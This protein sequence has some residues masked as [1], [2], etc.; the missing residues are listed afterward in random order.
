MKIKIKIKTFIF[1]IFLLGIIIVWGIPAATL[2]IADLLEYSPDKATLFYEKYAAYPTTSN[3]KGGYLYADSLVKSFSKYSIFLTGWGGGEDTSPENMKKAENILQD[4]MM[5]KPGNDSEKEYYIDSYKMLLDMSIATG[6]VDMLK[7]WISFGQ[8]SNEE[9]LIYISDMYNGFFLHVNG[10][11]E[12]AKKVIAKYENTELA[13]EKLDVLK[14]EISLFEG[15]YET[16]KNIYEKA[17]RD[18]TYWTLMESNI[19][20]SGGYYDRSFW[21]ERVMDDFK[22]DNVI[23]G[24]VTFEGEPMPFVE[25]YV[26]AVDGGFSSRG[27]SY[28]GITDENGEFETLGLKDGL[29]NIGIGVGGSLLSNKVLQRS[30]HQYTELDGKDGEIDFVFRNTFTVHSPEPGQKAAGDEFT[31]SWDEVEGAA[32]YTVEPVISEDPYKK[33]GTNMRSP[34]ADIN[35]VRKIKD[36]HATF[37][38]KMLRNQSMGFFGSDGTSI[39]PVSVLGIFLPGAEYPIVVNA[40]DEN[41]KLITSSLPMRTYYDQVPSIIVEGRLTVGEEMILRRDYPAAIEYYENILNDNPDDIDALR[42]LTRIYGIGWKLGEKNLERAYELGKRF[43]SLTGDNK[44]LLSILNMLDMDEIKENKEIID[45]VINES[46]GELEYDGNYFSSKYYIAFENYEAAREALNNAESISDNLFYLNMY[47]GDYKEAAENVKSNNYYLSRLSSNKIIE[48][49]NELENNPPEAY[50]RKIFNDFLLNL[51]KGIDYEDGKALYDET[52]KKITNNSIKT[53]LH[54][55]SL[56]RN[57]DVD[58]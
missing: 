52:V 39:E 56:D 19:Y 1:L 58:Y 27:E 42:Y 28:I 43:S 9:K 32:Y 48:S 11:R 53:I 47:F 26:Q 40:Y 16:A 51:V 3:I 54:E 49:L 33:S 2:A 20:G 45:L 22:G 25:I 15:N 46:K 55:I 37:N 44:I 21:F 10:D 13:D 6:D 35:G 29:Y 12:G 4:V 57:W 14:A 7:K 31:V 30:N 50:D 34:A 18:L 36:S 8:N 38:I 17:Q 23:R 41:N 5:E 24:K